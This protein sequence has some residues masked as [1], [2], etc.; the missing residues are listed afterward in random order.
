MGFAVRKCFVPK[1]IKCCDGLIRSSRTT[2]DHLTLSDKNFPYVFG[3]IC[4]KSISNIG[5]NVPEVGLTCSRPKY[6][7]EKIFY[8]KVFY[9]T[10]L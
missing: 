2:I 10:V 1:R 8:E 6:R 9:E 4:G 3:C 7:N 5:A